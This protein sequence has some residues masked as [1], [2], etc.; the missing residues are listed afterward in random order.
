M[1]LSIT[2]HSGRSTNVLWS[3]QTNL[4]L[5]TDGPISSEDCQT[6]DCLSEYAARLHS[7]LWKTNLF[8]VYTRNQQW[9]SRFSQKQI[10]CL[11]PSLEAIYEY[12]QKI[13][14]IEDKDLDA[15]DPLEQQ[16]KMILHRYQQN[17]ENNWN[18]QDLYH[19]L[20]SIVEKGF[21]SFTFDILFLL[22]RIALFSF[23]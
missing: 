4:A 2:R 13:L 5:F 3:S 8:E 17:L 15:N 16:Q 9:K 1:R 23:I 18:T 7:N 12:T 14:T 21:L 19:Y 22:M 6:D 20:K 11:P 10:L